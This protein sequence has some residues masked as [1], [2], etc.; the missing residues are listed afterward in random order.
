[1]KNK[2]RQL[3]F[4]ELGENFNSYMSDYDVNQRKSLIFNQLIKKNLKGEK[5]LEV[6]CGTGR[7]SEEI[8]KAGGNLIIL[9]IGQDLVKTVSELYCCSGSIGDACCLPFKDHSFDMVISS[10]CV[11]HTLNP[12]SAIKEMCRVC[13]SGGYVC[14]TTPNR[15]WYPLLVLSQQLGIRRFSG[16]ENW[17]FPQQAKKIYIEMNMVDIQFGGVHL[18]PFQIKFLRTFLNYIDS[19]GKYLYP[20]MINFGIIGMK[21]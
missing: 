1:M 20:L 14:I 16:I 13:R 10:E 4:N 11:E 17:I 7:F 18:L 6:G 8:R 21:R 12:E 2:N 5:I 3:Y 15:L 9:D 19:Y